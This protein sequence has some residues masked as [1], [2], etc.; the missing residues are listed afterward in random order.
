MKKPLT[1]IITVR[2]LFYLFF[3]SFVYRSSSVVVAKLNTSKQLDTSQKT[4][5]DKTFDPN[6]NVVK[7]NQ[8]T[9]E[10]DTSLKVNEGGE[11][12][13]W[14]NAFNFQKSWG[15]QVDPRTGILIAYVRAG[16]M[17]SNLGHGPN[18]DLEV[19]YNSNSL[20]DP[21]G[22]GR[23][24]SF[25]LTH[26]NLVN[27]QLST[28][29]GKVYNLQQNSN[30]QW[31]PQ[32]HKLKDIHISGSKS[33][34]FV[35]IYAN[36]LRETLNPDG[37]EI[38][39]EQQ[40]G[41]GVNFYYMQGT[42]LLSEI[43]DAQNH[44]IVLDRV[45]GLLTVTSYDSKGKPLNIQLDRFG[46]ELR[47]ITLPGNS[48]NSL[49]YIS[50]GY[51][52]NYLTN[53]V[54]PTGLKKNI[55]YNC[56]DAM[57]VSL[58]DNNQMRA[59]CV[60][61]MESVDPGAKQPAMATHYS[62]GKS[63]ANEHNYL[64]FNSGL[65]IQP[66]PK[67]DILFATP[68]SY[69]YKTIQDNGVIQQIRTYN[70]YHLLINAQIISNHT[71]HLI[72]QVQNFF[73]RTD[74]DDGCAHTR[75]EDLPITY[76]LPLKTVIKNWGD[77]TGPPATEVTEKTY[78]LQGRITSTKD[79]YGRVKKI[80]YCPVTGDAFCPAEPVDWSLTT[81][82]ESVTSY[83]SDQVF[84]VSRLP[85]ITEH[86]YY[87]QELNADGHGYT[88]VLVHKV[89]RSG[90]QQI[91]TTR[92]YY[93]N[94][95]DI[96]KYGLIKR[97]TVTGS[98]S[99]VAKL[100]A[101]NK[102]YYYILNS[103]YKTKT[104]YNTVET[105]ENQFKRS[106]AVTTSMYTNQVLEMADA[107]NKN[108]SYYHYDNQGRIVQ[109]DSGVNT[110]FTVSKRYQYT[111]SPQLVELITIAANGLKE[112]IIFD[113]AGRKLAKFNQAIASSGEKEPDQWVPVTSVSY[114]A[115][116]Q[117]SSKYD[118]Y[119]DTQ[120]KLIKLITTFSYDNLGRIYKVNLPDKETIVKIYDDPDRCAVS[121]K[122]DT[123]NNYSPISV[124]HGNVLEKP[125]KKIVLPANFNHHLSAKQLCEVSSKLLVA[126][127]SFITYDGFGRVATS[128][129]TMGR[130]VS[131]EYD[132]A[133]RVV[134]IIDP[135]GNR[136]NNIYNLAGQIIQKWISPINSHKRYLLSS[137]QYNAAG[138][139]LWKAGEDGRKTLYTYTS[140]GNIKT[141]TT[142]LAHII[143][144][145][146]N[147]V[148]LP[149]SK[150]IDGREVS[151][152]EYNPVI[153]L[154]VK[155]TDITGVTTWSYSDDGKTQQLIHTGVDGYQSYQ[156]KWQYDQ[157]RRMISI[158]DIYG[159]KT[160]TS[161]D[162]FGRISSINYQELS[163]IKKLLE[164]FV[165]D[166]LSRIVAL[167][168]GSGMHRTVSYDS[169]DQTESISDTLSSGLLSSW[170]YRYDEAGNIIS[171]TQQNGNQQRATQHYK[172][173][174][175][176]NLI[177]MTCSGSSDLSLCPRDTSFYTMALN[178]AP[179]ITRQT[180]IF[181]PMN[182]METVKETL[183]NTDKQ[184]TLSKITDYSYTDTQA[185]LRL[186][187]I[188]TTRNN[189]IPVSANFLYDNAGNMI[190][191]SEGNKIAYNALNQITS[192]TDPLG[193]QTHYFYDGSGREVKEKSSSGDIRHLFY[194]NK[195]LVGEKISN[196]QMETH[197]ISHLGVAKAI[198]GVI[199]EYYEKNY[200]GDVTSVLT[201]AVNGGYYLSQRN[202]YSPYGMVWHAKSVASL[203]W[204]LQ[205]Y[206]GFNDEQTDPA[207][208]WQFLGAGHRTYNPKQR[209]FVS[210][211]PAGD[212]YA[213]GSNNP[214]MNSDPSGNMPKWLGS[215]M[216]VLGYVGTMGMAVFH[217][218][219]ANVVGVA[220]VTALSCTAV[221]ASLMWAGAMTSTIIANVGTT[222]AAGSLVAVSA[223]IPTNRGLSIASAVTG[224]MLMAV[225]VV[226]AGMLAFTRSAA[227]L[228]TEVEEAS[229]EG[230]DDLL[231]ISSKADVDDLKVNEG[232]DA[233]ISEGESDKPV[234][235]MKQYSE[236]ELN[237]ALGNIYATLDIFAKRI[238]FVDNEA[239]VNNMWSAINVHIKNMQ[240]EVFIIL[241]Q[242]RILNKFIVLDDLAEFLGF[243]AAYDPER[244]PARFT[245]LYRQLSQPL[246]TI[247]VDEASQILKNSR[248]YIFYE[249]NMTME[250][251]FWCRDYNKFKARGINFLLLTGKMEDKIV[252]LNG[253]LM[254]F[255]V[256]KG[257]E[258]A[259]F[260]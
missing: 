198:D 255:A 55:I 164:S 63:S 31:W 156:F 79:A 94:P 102:N 259:I 203:P 113:G 10:S 201:R 28:S 80:H 151:H 47:T 137:A 119:T 124:V 223:T 25:N 217:K 212:G 142:P 93:H 257:T 202:T 177:S 69:T 146:Y 67:Q 243:D 209:Y 61:S 66:E 21:D 238:I 232:M 8:Y 112:K 9:A 7:K 246:K 211:D 173:D 184:E 260:Y 16:S 138:E 96:F 43:S 56:T 228:P 111:V 90:D 147:A 36:G 230:E 175:L 144:W 135:A 35:I 219:W 172:Y 4:A 24:W 75:F 71:N 84:D 107:E 143:S 41:Y 77:S 52:N 182:R 179:V 155:R 86:N 168:Y 34:G 23:G 162:N 196:T 27:N 248:D 97:V 171:I 20:A 106:P 131:R 98:V 13:L 104:V 165:Y 183:L 225:N 195:M 54:Y 231:S 190:T 11:S 110:D 109:I 101:T 188:T 78:D 76:S 1:K 65:D 167:K 163:G 153:T 222:I 227:L 159:N 234:K 252:D 180:Y 68:A 187:K 29:Q 89:I 82:V 15:T 121:Y 244:I 38:R 114:D 42:H 118:Y 174:S 253:L 123:Q 51:T 127:A 189:N 136:I 32:Y 103:D 178:Q 240:K 53:I 154:P 88:L 99:P 39:L 145:K 95:Q 237:A 152:L 206:T 216:N 49:S 160:M 126:K 148:G 120:G 30:G 14:S 72:S 33:A 236:V 218:K 220:L 45:S 141:V 37:Y 60:V 40:N 235:F 85:E 5:A 108:I 242:A 57:K 256:D 46:G 258:L 2:A 224:I 251:T 117:I 149:V 81:Q 200:K 125:T 6:R 229:L 192:V 19:N 150:M 250:C 169:Y 139:L 239:T 247:D 226:M 233:D 213:F 170:K 208:G 62:Y 241:N 64:A 157:N 176:N 132:G 215:F 186:Q 181:N 185:P 3:L 199:H 245:E 50:M 191:D 73:C 18:I 115:H 26:F 134:T 92:Q 74:Q 100:T 87:Q 48:N 91:T 158:T 194:T 254:D 197:V 161:Y 70:K 133:G 83:P 205:T 22:L 193:K 12:S 44:K 17:I 129:D 140:D 214:V 204:Y 59:M 207:T 210:E 166:N 105:G 116:G 122:Y 130:K 58:W 221:L 249:N 128:T